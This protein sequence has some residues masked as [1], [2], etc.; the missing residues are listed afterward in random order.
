MQACRQKH[1][2]LPPSVALLDIRKR[3]LRKKRH[4]ISSLFEIYLAFASTL[5]E[6]LMS[7]RA[8]TGMLAPELLAA[9][10]IANGT[11][12]L[13]GAQ[14]HR[15]LLCHAK[16]FAVAILGTYTELATS[17]CARFGGKTTVPSTTAQHAATAWKL[18]PGSHGH[19]SLVRRDRCGPGPSFHAVAACCAVVEG[20]VV[21]SRA[22][23]LLSYS[24]GPPVGR[25]PTTLRATGSPG[26]R[27]HQEGDI[28]PTLLLG[29]DLGPS[30]YTAWDT[31]HEAADT[32]DSDSLLGG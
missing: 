19:P 2:A 20:T 9:L 18:G 25:F 12:G 4:P 17:A 27:N 6:S 32:V 29:L 30:D 31:P 11:A 16:L 5:G 10:E 7:H 15:F 21:F 13:D 14:A 3:D 8:W 24:H 1:I 26:R 22:S 28:G 23:H